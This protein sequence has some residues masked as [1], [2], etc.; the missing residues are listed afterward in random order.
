M[1][2]LREKKIYLTIYDLEISFSSENVLSENC[3]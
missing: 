2:S 1:K 3:E